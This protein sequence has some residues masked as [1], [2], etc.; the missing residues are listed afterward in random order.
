MSRSDLDRIPDHARLWV[1]GANRRLTPSEAQR[2]E[3][4]MRGFLREWAAHG[5]A[6]A[7]APA[8]LQE[9]FLLVAADEEKATASGCSIDA[10]TRHVREL[11]RELEVRLLDGQSVWF[12]DSAG[13]IRCVDRAEFRALAGHGE[14]DGRTRVFDLTVDTLGALR[15]GRWEVPAESSW[16][17]RLLVSRTAEEAI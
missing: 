4:R 6:L 13:S 9:R 3:E 15:A 2:L 11:E 17:A 5:R 1:F 16:H 14:I 8:V 12:R 7:A 10:L